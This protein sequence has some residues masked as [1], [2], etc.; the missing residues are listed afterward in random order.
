MNLNQI[1]VPVLDVEKAIE[2]Y[3]KLGLRLIVRALP[4]YARFECPEG[5][6]T[7]SLHQT[8]RLPNGEGIVIYFECENLDE[9]VANLSRSGIEFSEMP[10]D[11]S[12]LWRE[13]HLR[14]LDGNFLILFHAGDNRKNPPWRIR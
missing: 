12:W 1:T 8:E 3:E 2:F 4:H 7:F 5:D 11:K 6:A 10:N 9:Q 14:D 13:A